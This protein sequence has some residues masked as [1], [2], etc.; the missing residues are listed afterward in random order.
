[1]GREIALQ[2]LFACEMN[3][4]RPGADTFDPYFES[5]VELV[6]G[7]PDERSVRRAKKHAERLYTEVELHKEEI[8]D[9][10]SSH[11]KSWDFSRLSG[12]CRNLLRMATAE[13]LYVDTVPVVVSINE[14]VA[15]AR[16]YGGLE[17]VGFVNGILNAIKEKRT[18]SEG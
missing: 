11:C 4:N 15:M 13:M 7:T 6:F 3:G 18:G 2:Y 9:I 14:A 1:M 17:S 5:A 10:V 8:D 16:D 12:I